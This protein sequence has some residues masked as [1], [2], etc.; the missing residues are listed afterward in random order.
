M[1]YLISYD[2]ENDRLRTRVAK[3][4]CRHGCRRVQ[5]SVFVAGFMERRDYQRLVS[6]LRV[7]ERQFGSGDSLLVVGLEERTALD[8]LVFGDNNILA[9][10][11]E[12]VLKIVV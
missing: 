12:R 5:R 4:L 11:G 7:S 6:D 8:V 3:K 2:I 9:E 10:L 1:H